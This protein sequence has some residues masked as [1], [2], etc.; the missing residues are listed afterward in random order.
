MGKTR[1]KLADQRV[2]VPNTLAV[3]MC[4]YTGSPVS[5]RLAHTR[6]VIGGGREWSP[7]DLRRVLREQ[8]GLDVVALRAAG[9][10]ESRSAFWVRDRAGTVSVLKIMPGAPPEAAGKLRALDAVLARLRDRGYPAPRFRVI[11]QVPGLVFWVQPRLPGS[12]LDRGRPEPDYPALAR[13]LPELL[14]LAAPP[15]RR[16]HHPPAPAPG[17]ARHHRHQ[18]RPGTLNPRPL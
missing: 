5:V 18:P 3:P 11:G 7:S 15:S 8:A 10:G 16:R 2:D 1:A 12:T 9:A 17:Q 4:S 13:L 6:K 14:R